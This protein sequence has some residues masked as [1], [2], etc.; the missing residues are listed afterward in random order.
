M[1]KNYVVTV[2][3]RGRITVPFDCW[4]DANCKDLILKYNVKNFNMFN[5]CWS[6][7]KG[8]QKSMS[9]RITTPFNRGMKL[10]LIPDMKHKQ[11]MVEAA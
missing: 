3:T 6:N 9:Y 2:G 1:K 10:T 5:W 11:I 4:M 8:M 7:M